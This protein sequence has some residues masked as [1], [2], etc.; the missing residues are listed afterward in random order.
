MKSNYL[1][2]CGN[3]NS[4][5]NT[6]CGFNYETFTIGESHVLPAPVA[7]HADMLCA[8]AA[9]GTV[10][11]YDRQLMNML[12]SRKIRCFYPEGI[13]GNQYPFD[14]SLNCL[15]IGGLFVANTRYCDHDILM[16]AGAVGKKIVHVN[17]GYTRCST[18]V[19]SPNAAITADASIAEAL[20]GEGIDVLQ[21]FQLRLVASLKAEGFEVMNE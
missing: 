5:I 8:V 12:I 20:R 1:A 18:A 21:E 15:H 3:C 13:L 11:T 7:N 6:L 14:S 19:V 2:V 4:I 10:L 17:Q 16:R 9:D